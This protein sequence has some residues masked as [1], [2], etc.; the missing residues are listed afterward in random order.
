MSFFTK[1][2][3]G[4]LTGSY[5]TADGLINDQ[6]TKI[7]TGSIDDGALDKI[8]GHLASSIKRVH[9][10]S[11]HTDAHPGHFEQSLFV[12]GSVV[13]GA[14]GA[15]D[16]GSASL[17][18]RDLFIDGTANIDSLI[19]DTADI[20]GGTV[21]GITSLTAAGD[22]DIGA[23]DLRAA[24]LTADGLTASRVVFAGTDGVL[25]D[26]SDM[27]FA[28]DTLTVTKLGAFE[29]AGAIN[30][31]SQ[32]MTNVDI[33]SGT[34]DAITSLTVANDVDIGNFKL[35]SK[36]LEASD[37]TA[38]R[39]VFAGANGLLADDSDMTFSGDTLTVTKL[40]A[41]EQAGAVDFSDEVMTNVNIDSGAI[42]GAIIG[43]NSAVAGSFSTINAS[44]NVTIAG[45]LDVNG[46]TT[47]IDTA[48]MAIQDGIIGIGTSGSVAY[49]P[50]ASHRGIV[51]GAG[52]LPTAQAVFYHG[53][54]SDDRFHL[55]ASATSPLSASF[56]TPS[57]YKT[58]RLGA[59]ELGSA[60]NRLLLDTDVT[61]DAAADIV[62]D[63]GGLDVIPGADKT[64]RLGSSAAQW[65]SLYVGMGDENFGIFLDDDADTSIR[66]AADDSIDFRVGGTDLYGMIGSG[67]LPVG[68]G[69]KDLGSNLAQW[70]D[71]Y[72]NGKAYIDQ[73]GEA[74]D[75]DNQNMTNVD[76][77]SGAI[78]GAIVGAASAAAGTFTALVANDSLVVNANASIV[79]DAANEIQLNVA[80][81]GSQS[82][83]IFNVE[84]GDGTDK[85]SVSSA[86]LTTAASLSATVGHIS[87]LN[88]AM[89]CGNQ[90]MTNVNI[91][92]GAIELAALNI[93]GG[94][95]MGDILAD[96]DLIIIDDGGAGT[97]KKSVMT[98]IPEY[99]WTKVQKGVLVRTAVLA[100][101]NDLAVGFNI[102]A[103]SYSVNN[104]P[105]RDVYLNGQ[106][107]VE[108]EEDAS[109]KDFY[110]G[111][112]Q[113]NIK[114]EF[115]L[116][117]GDVVQVV[118]R[119]SF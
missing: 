33:D 18:W 75:C 81:H 5:G 115:P 27:T 47:T 11:S 14:D 82:V 26:D 110:V 23:H 88:G 65:K 74:L 44:S 108:G 102:W 94:T 76:I 90:A 83:N 96:A 89:D 61:I 6:E 20:N 99:V 64:H 31:A 13:P 54:S 19:A 12:T 67:F 98:K 38:T 22:L 104:R 34:V 78:D 1:M 68:D 116:S 40:G 84:L 51:F 32:N 117:V 72:I 71:I 45:N 9:G 10:H 52:T 56:A 46:T 111:S 3:V 91:D 86:G 85:L 66:A 37:L 93:D 69:T 79:G 103:P 58:L 77:D 57:S 107:L 7:A 70:K 112:D 42:D 39:V 53:G 106:L 59:V 43:A 95:S 21:D 113:G 8:L 92:T 50:A 17:E 87:T 49:A 119:G 55:G 25:S 2:R 63:A 80:A 29:A 48:N 35:T 28:T 114:F 60:N 97:N 100:A 41:Y 105:L 73:L 16:L 118:M 15:H 24:T 4:Q 62:L 30:F 36:A 109:N 101:G